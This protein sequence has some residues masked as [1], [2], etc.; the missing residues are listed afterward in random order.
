MIADKLSKLDARLRHYES[1]SKELHTLECRYACKAERFADI[2]TDAVKYY[3]FN[4]FNHK[5]HKI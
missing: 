5:F 1:L 4:F 3:S 2:E